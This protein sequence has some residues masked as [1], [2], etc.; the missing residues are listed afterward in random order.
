[1]N[2]LRPVTDPPASSDPAGTQGLSYTANP[3]TVAI[4]ASD[5]LVAFAGLA[6]GTVGLY[7]VN[8]TVP[9]GIAAGNQ[10]LVV[11]AG[12]QFESVRTAGPMSLP[13]PPARRRAAPLEVLSVIM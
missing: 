2:G 8:V 11:T 12:G 4:G 1:M 10:T 6:P 5:A 3:V 9:A 13:A 7:Q